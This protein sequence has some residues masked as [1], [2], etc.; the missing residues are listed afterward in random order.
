[1][2]LELKPVSGSEELLVRD[3]LLERGSRSLGRSA[4]CDWRLPATAKA[5]SK[6]HCTITRTNGGFTLRDESSNG[7]VVDG[8]LVHQGETVD[9]NDKSR[10]EFGGFAFSVA[11]RGTPEIAVEDPDRGLRL[12]D[13]IPSVSAILADVA[14]G[15][16]I[17][18]SVLGERHDGTSD[19]PPAGVTA[20][21]RREIDPGWSGPPDPG[22]LA[23][24]LPDNW[25]LD[26]DFISNREHMA[27]TRTAAPVRGL[28]G[29]RDRPEESAPESAPRAGIA[30]APP[31]PELRSEPETA[32]PMGLAPAPTPAADQGYDHLANREDPRLDAL[33]RADLAWI[34]ALQDL[35]ALP[36]SPVRAPVHASDGVDARIA[37]LR[38]RQ[39]ALLAT[40][41]KMLERAT[42]TLDPRM[43][44]ARRDNA[45][46]SRAAGLLQALPVL[47]ERDC[48]RAYKALFE[49][50]GRAIGLPD[51]LAR[52]AG[53]ED[54][55]SEAA[56]SPMTM[57]PDERND[58]WQ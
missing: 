34:E 4:Q 54:E 31:V 43:I 55:P 26:S 23:P 6:R 39:E 14:P 17:A 41:R 27:A 22:Q 2:R 42:K 18:G 49:R 44:E 5:V 47:S 7:T 32:V 10:I 19:W 25:H 28:S 53:E 12:A 3:W 16:S 45:P 8:R 11:V 52:L 46:A 37:E 58:A 1:M 24:I 15:G 35:F 50:D 56:S 51:M 40:L 21:P 13:D 30:D 33:I 38:A 57:E 20:G 29:R 36:P 48:W 9:L